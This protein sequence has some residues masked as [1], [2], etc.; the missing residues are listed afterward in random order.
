M[1]CCQQHVFLRLKNSLYMS[2]LVEMKNKFER[3][4]CISCKWCP[5][6]AAAASCYDGLPFAA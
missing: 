3:I 4:S 6:E 5:L 2:S 1:Q